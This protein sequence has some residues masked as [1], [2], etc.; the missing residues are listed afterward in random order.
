MVNGATGTVYPVFD[1]KFKIGTKGTSSADE[2]MTMIA[3]IEN[4]APSIDGGLEEWNP[5][6]SE[7]WGDVMMT[8]KKLS[9][10]FSGKR[11]YGDV[12]NDYV[13]SL[14]WKTGNDVVSM[15]EWEFPS[16]AKVTFNCIVNVTTPSGGDSTGLDAL[17]FDIMCKGK[18]TFVNA[19][20]TP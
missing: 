1:N 3:N 15:F 8:S 17:E 16:G 19:P 6:E 18:P 10:S 5:M 4:F 14:A 2:D 12:G 9:F 11:T 13:A 20:V 7:G